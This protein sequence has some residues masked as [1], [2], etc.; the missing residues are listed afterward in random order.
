MTQTTLPVVR[1]LPPEFSIGEAFVKLAAIPG[2]GPQILVA[3]LHVGGVL[4]FSAQI[5]NSI[6]NDGD[7]LFP[8]IALAPAS[9]LY[10]TC[11]SPRRADCESGKAGR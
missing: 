8:A 6:A 3:S 9:A 7:A 1:T 5:G 4:P 2:C 11:I 10:P